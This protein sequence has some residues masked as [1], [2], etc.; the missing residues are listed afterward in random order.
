MDIISRKERSNVNT[1]II[2]LSVSSRIAECQQRILK[3][4]EDTM[5]K[6]KRKNRMDKLSR[7]EMIITLAMLCPLWLVFI[8]HDELF[9]LFLLE[10]SFMAVIGLMFF[11]MV[12]TALKISE[13]IQRILERWLR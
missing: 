9:I 12:W 6:R 3:L 8:E 7:T 1:L 5:R 13:W 11:I 4:R 2:V 10:I